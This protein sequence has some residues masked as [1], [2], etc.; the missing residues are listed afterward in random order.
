MFSCCCRMIAMS[1]LDCQLN[2]LSR[3]ARDG[4][5]PVPCSGVV[6]C[7]CVSMIGV[8]A[9]RCRSTLCGGIEGS[10]E[11]LNSGM[12]FG[13]W[14]GATWPLHGIQCVHACVI[15]LAAIS[16]LTATL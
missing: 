11:A 4:E 16:T 13:L 7:L 3:E 15:L 9:S 8:F 5:L 14:S 10:V 12:V 1:Q 2:S 6:V